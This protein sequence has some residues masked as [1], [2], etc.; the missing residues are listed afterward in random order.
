MMHSV[1]PSRRTSLSRCDRLFTFLNS[2]VRPTI[3][4][5]GDLRADGLVEIA[6]RQRQ[7]GR[8]IGGRLV[9]RQTADDVQIRVALRHLELPRFS[10]TASSIA[11]R[12]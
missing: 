3:A 10:S 4:D 8:E 12:L 2:P 1:K 5:G 6:R 7:N 11:A 9:Q